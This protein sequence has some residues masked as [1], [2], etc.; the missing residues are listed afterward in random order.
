VAACVS[1]AVA[2]VLFVWRLTV[3]LPK[4]TAKEKKEMAE[5]ASDLLHQLLE[6]MRI[7][8]KKMEGLTK[9]ADRAESDHARN[10]RGIELMQDLQR[11]CRE[12]TLLLRQEIRYLGDAIKD[13]AAR[14]AN[15][16]R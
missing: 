15:V 1:A 4:K 9:S 14:V 6:T 12:E 13:L 16:T 7:V 8:D 3:A 11:T 10:E 2:G 5:T